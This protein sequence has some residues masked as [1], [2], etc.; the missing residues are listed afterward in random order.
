[1]CTY[2]VGVRSG[3]QLV[4]ECHL[5]SEPGFFLSFAVETGYPLCMTYSAIHTP[6][7][8]SGS[9]DQDFAPS[10]CFRFEVLTDKDRAMLGDVEVGVTSGRGRKLVT[11][12]HIW[13]Q[14]FVEDVRH[15]WSDERCPGSDGS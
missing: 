6:L 10:G 14:G 11:Y 5:L 13:S 12:P 1:M 7:R 9:D 15:F 4:I 3:T 8:Q 2:V